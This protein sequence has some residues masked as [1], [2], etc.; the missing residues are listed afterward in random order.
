MND[1]LLR[2]IAEALERVSPR[3]SDAP[4]FTEADAYVWHVDPDRLESVADVNR[5][6][7]SGSVS[8]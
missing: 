1:D 4:D 5:I 6:D 2:R 7:L 8:V 3:P